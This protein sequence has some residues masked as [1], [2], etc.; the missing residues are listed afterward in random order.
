MGKK[1]PNSTK[2]GKIHHGD[3]GYCHT[4]GAAFDENGKRDRS[5]DDAHNASPGLLDGVKEFFGEGC[6]TCGRTDFLEENGEE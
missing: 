6:Q 1:S 2:Y 3:Q 5:M 4:D